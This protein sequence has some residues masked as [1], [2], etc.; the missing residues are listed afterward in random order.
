MDT[1]DVQ[2]IGYEP[3]YNRVVLCPTCPLYTDKNSQHN[4]HLYN[5]TTA[6]VVRHPQNV[7][8][9]VHNMYCMIV[10]WI[11]INC[12]PFETLQRFRVML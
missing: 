4:D 12:G 2:Y 10:Q 7:G 1:S 8:Q 3:L 9:A 5:L 11:I 6:L